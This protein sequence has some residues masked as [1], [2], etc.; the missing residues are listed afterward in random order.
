MTILAIISGGSKGFG[1]ALAVEL[2]THYQ[3]IHLFLLGRDA[4]GL[5]TTSSLINQRNGHATVNN[6]LIDLSDI[7]KL[8]TQIQ[9][10]LDSIDYTKYSRIL[11]I[12][13]HGSLGPLTSIEKLPISK[14]R[15]EIDLNVTSVVILNTLFIR[16]FN[17]KTEGFSNINATIVN[18]SSLA[19]IKPFHSWGLYCTGKSARDMLHQIIATE[20]ADK[21]G[22]DGKAIITTLNYAPGP[23]DTDMQTEIRETCEHESTRTYFMEM[24]KEEKLVDP[25]DSAKKL[26]SILDTNKFESGAHIDYFDK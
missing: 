18:I 7:D 23:L 4:K 25:H 20:N 19:A 12:N 13:N 1:R 2:A 6:V 9:P 21:I 24:K 10:L 11:F 15:T 17:S 3:H 22:S 8:E 5:D 26:V 16:H 14:I